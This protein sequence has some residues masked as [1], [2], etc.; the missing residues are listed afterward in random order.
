MRGLTK[1]PQITDWTGFAFGIPGCSE[2][3]FGNP[4]QKGG[5]LKANHNIKES[6]LRS[7]WKLVSNDFNAVLAP[8]DKDIK[9]PAWLPALSVPQMMYSSA[10]PF[11]QAT[12]YPLA[13]CSTPIGVQAPHSPT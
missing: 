10:L 13:V 12:S 9:S 4:F 7:C 11:L 1:D 6:P 3:R 8:D 5:V 2:I